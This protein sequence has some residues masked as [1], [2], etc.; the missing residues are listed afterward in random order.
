MKKREEKVKN[1]AKTDN[2]MVYNCH[3]RIVW[4]TKYRLKLLVDGA[5]EELK[6]IVEEVACENSASVEEVEV[7]PDYIHVLLECNPHRVGKIIRTMKGR[8]SRVLREKY[9]F[10]KSRTPSLWTRSYF[11]ATTGGASLD[12]V[13]KYIENQKRRV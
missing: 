1:T 9:S 7:M 8:S 13:K 12:I 11:V 4:C 5:D 2:H 10:I 3:Y 6:R